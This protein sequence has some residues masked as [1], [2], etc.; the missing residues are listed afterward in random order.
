[1]AQVEKQRDGRAAHR[2]AGA[3]LLPAGRARSVLVGPGAFSSRAG[4][5]VFRPRANREGIRG[6]RTQ[7]RRLENSFDGKV[8]GVKGP[9]RGAAGEVV[10]PGPGVLKHSARR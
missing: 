10:V 4:W 6:V 8:K 1:M 7:A 2:G 9:V 5:P 3:R